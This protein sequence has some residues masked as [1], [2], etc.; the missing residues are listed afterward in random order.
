MEY[1]AVAAL[2]AL[3]NRLKIEIAASSVKAEHVQLRNQSPIATTNVVQNYWG[4]FFAIFNSYTLDRVQESRLRLVYFV[5][6]VFNPRG[7]CEIDGTA[8]TV[9]PGSIVKLSQAMVGRCRE[10][11]CVRADSANK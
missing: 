6:R 11:E 4:R 2:P 9:I 8:R 1:S 5:F 10:E 7:V 3:F